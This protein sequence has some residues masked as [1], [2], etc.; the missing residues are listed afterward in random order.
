MRLLNAVT[1]KLIAELDCS[2]TTIASPEAKIYKEDDSLKSYNRMKLID[3]TQYKI[4][5][6]KPAPNDKAP[7]AQGV[8]VL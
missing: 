4:P 1:W 3:R 2:T 8:G 7:P 6:V 5:V